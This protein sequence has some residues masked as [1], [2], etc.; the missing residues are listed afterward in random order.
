MQNIVR[1]D[2]AENVMLCMNDWVA[3]RV[4]AVGLSDGLSMID[5]MYQSL[6]STSEL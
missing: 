6:V 4:P 3:I 1:S 2:G 5:S